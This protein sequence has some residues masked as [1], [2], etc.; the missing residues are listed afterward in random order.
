MDKRVKNILDALETAY[1]EAR[2]Q[3]SHE[4]PFQ[5]LVATIL[6][7]RCTDKQVNEVT[8]RLF[9]AYPAPKDLAEADIK[10]IEEIIRPTG[11]FHNKAKNIQACAKALAKRHGG[12]VPRDMESLTAL[13]G[14]GRKTA[15]VV[16]SAA[17]GEQAVVVDTHVARVSR[18]LGLTSSRD[19]VKIEQDLMA[20]LPQNRWS[21]F[22]I[23]TIFHGRN[24]CTA[25]K[26]QCSGCPLLQWCDYGRQHTR[27]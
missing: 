9:S 3:L 22:S 1:P 23:Q 7:A 18:R 13:P 26:P 4:N 21:A 10:D 15:N 24:L 25:K 17:F 16:K 5:L 11:F 19:P 14:V 8:P 12:K 2:T 27:G 6:S 20:V